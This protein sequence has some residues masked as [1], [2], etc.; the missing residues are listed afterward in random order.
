MA[1]NEKRK[2]I[3]MYG[4]Y[5]TGKTLHH[6]RLMQHLF[7]DELNNTKVYFDDH[8]MS[9]LYSRIAGIKAKG[10]ILVVHRSGSADINSD[11][12]LFLVAIQQSIQCIIGGKRI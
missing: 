8:N 12:R 10:E 4:A 2:P 6:L 3:W 1:S 11:G 5:G 9:S 7:E